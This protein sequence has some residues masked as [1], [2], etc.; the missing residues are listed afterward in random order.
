MRQAYSNASVE[1][2]MLLAPPSATRGAPVTNDAVAPRGE[3][4][5][6]RSRCR[7]PRR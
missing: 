6:T 1:T 3:A 4:A 5:R 7:H 2:S